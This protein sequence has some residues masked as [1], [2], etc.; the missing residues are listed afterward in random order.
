MSLELLPL[1]QS[2]SVAEYQD[3]YVGKVMTL[4]Q[5]NG[6]TLSGSA[7]ESEITW[8][9]KGGGPNGDPKIDSVMVVSK[10]LASCFRV[11][12]IVGADNQNVS[13]RGRDNTGNPKSQCV[14]N[15][16][17]QTSP[18]SV[19]VSSAS[20]SVNITHATVHNNSVA[21]RKRIQK[22]ACITKLGKRRK[23]QTDQSSKQ[24]HRHC[25]AVSINENNV[26]NEDFHPG[27]HM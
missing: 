6:G 23:K 9:T 19:S 22:K 11:L 10:S 21:G 20:A 16:L 2:K 5:W 13:S 15:V 14:S 12:N 25:A 8:R 17:D 3:D 7:S 26:E 1:L 4:F 18:S 24:K 27:I